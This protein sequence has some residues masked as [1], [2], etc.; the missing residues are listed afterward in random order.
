MAPANIKSAAFGRFLK[1]S[2]FCGRQIRSFCRLRQHLR[3][4][5][6]LPPIYIMDLYFPW[7]W[8]KKKS[9]KN[10]CTFF[11]LFNRIA[12][13]R[14]TKYSIAWK[15][16]KLHIQYCTRRNWRILKEDSKSETNGK[17][18]MLWKLLE[19]GRH[20]EQNQWMKGKGSPSN[21][22]EKIG[23]KMCILN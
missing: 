19:E 4:P 8:E 16:K 15:E 18:C 22:T 5:P 10:I 20:L 13:K 21:H 17:K 23:W 6:L 1:K 7:D 9:K 3:P 2:A 11:L 14:K 12:K